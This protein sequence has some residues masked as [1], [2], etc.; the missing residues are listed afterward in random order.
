MF[1]RRRNDI[2]FA[3]P[4]ELLLQIEE[5]L[6]PS[7]QLAH[8]A[9]LLNIFSAYDMVLNFNREIVLV[10]KRWHE[11]KGRHTRRMYMVV[12]YFSL[13]NLACVIFPL[14]ALIDESYSCTAGMWAFCRAWYYIVVVNTSIL[15]L[16][17]DVM[18]LI[19]VNSVY[20]WNIRIQL[21][22]SLV[23]G[24]LSVTSAP[25]PS[26]SP[27]IPGCPTS[28]RRPVAQFTLVAWAP[29]ILSEVTYLILMLNSLAHLMRGLGLDK[30]A[31]SFS[32][33]L[34]PSIDNSHN[35]SNQHSNNVTQSNT[36]I[37]SNL[38]VPEP[39]NEG[40][41]LLNF[42][43]DVVFNPITS[44]IETL[45]A[46]LMPAQGSPQQR[47]KAEQACLLC[48]HLWTVFSWTALQQVS[49][50]VPTMM[51]FIGHGWVYF[52][53]AI[54]AKI[55]NAILVTT[56][57]G[58]LQ[59]AAIPWMMALL[60]V[61]VT[62]IY[63]SMVRYLHFGL[64]MKRPQLLASYDGENY[65][66]YVGFEGDEWVN[67]GDFDVRMIT[68]VRRMRARVKQQV[69]DARPRVMESGWGDH[70]IGEDKGE[71]EGLEE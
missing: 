9:F 46:I 51:V 69:R 20:G 70:Q 61:V 50:L 41:N 64:P 23:V 17:P 43:S 45:Q 16:L 38:S 36:T 28:L 8:D 2:A 34:P 67:E 71:E 57:S 56:Q 47:N 65:E 1:V 48:A 25:M 39:L 27:S 22:T 49:R 3:L 26:T 68:I 53:L 18:L 14:S 55:V 58:P 13:F 54:C 19:R 37:N 52:G 62:R 42:P 5:P 12:R 29:S 6:E 32:S 59:A 33:S 24:I 10:W 31:T 21:A 44:Q 40:D 4:R 63:L 7:A 66:D 35:H 30:E 15:A 60:P 11:P